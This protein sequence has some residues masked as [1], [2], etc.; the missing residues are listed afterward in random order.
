MTPDQQKKLDNITGA[1]EDGKWF[2]MWAV[3][4]PDADRPSSPYADDL[5]GFMAGE[6]HRWCKPLYEALLRHMIN[7]DQFE[8]FY[9]R[10]MRSSSAFLSTFSGPSADGQPSSLDAFLEDWF[11]NNPEEPPDDAARAFSPV[12]Q[13]G[14]LTLPGDGSGLDASTF[15]PIDSTRN[16]SIPQQTANHPEITM[17]GPMRPEDE[18]DFTLAWAAIQ[19]PTS[20]G[21]QFADTFPSAGQYQD[22]GDP[23][24]STS[25]F[26]GFGFGQT[27]PHLDAGYPLAPRVYRGPELFQH[28]S[29]LSGWYGPRT[30]QQSPTAALSGGLMNDYGNDNFTPHM[31]HHS[32]GATSFIQAAA[33]RHS[34]GGGHAQ[35]AVGGRVSALQ[36]RQQQQ[37]N[38]YER[39]GPR[40]F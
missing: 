36:P 38:Q 5:A 35:G 3:L 14:P 32:P 6:V 17:D 8:R 9:G 1:G 2:A 34:G 24:P 39:T 12:P 29:S 40:H 15:Q 33:G 28:G 19:F 20:D 37:H 10:L 7:D 16:I 23:Q 26:D 21:N 18:P 13:T 11:G 27:N 30:P 25:S 22:A 31:A 4:F